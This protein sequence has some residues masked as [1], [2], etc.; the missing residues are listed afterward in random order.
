MDG[1]W[2]FQQ[3]S[4]GNFIWNIWEKSSH[5]PQN[6]CL[7]SNTQLTHSVHPLT[8]SILHHQHSIRKLLENSLPP[9]FHF[10]GLNTPYFL[11]LLVFPSNNLIYGITKSRKRTYFSTD[12]KVYQGLFQKKKLLSF[13]K[14]D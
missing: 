4:Y 8:Q 14:R 10:K 3:I 13:L 1:I 2:V 11:K 7:L 5:L 12:M 6:I 9:I